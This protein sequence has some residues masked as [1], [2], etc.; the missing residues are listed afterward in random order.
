MLMFGVFSFDCGTANTFALLIVG[1]IVQGWSG[2]LMMALSQTLLVR[3]FPRSQ[4]GAAMAVWTIA[5]LLAPALG[6]IIGGWLCETF[7][8]PLI[9][10]INVPIAVICASLIW[11]RLKQFEEQTSRTPVD[12]VGF[13]LL[14]IFVGSLQ[15]VLDIGKDRDWFASL[16]VCVLSGVGAIGFVSFL[17]W[18]LT[19]EHPIVDLRVFRHRGFVTCVILQAMVFASAFSGIVLT[20]LWLQTYM[21]YSATQAGLTMAWNALLGFVIGPIAG[22]LMG[23]LDGRII[24]FSGLMLIV[25]A[26]WLRAHYTTD[27]S[28]FQ[29][30]LPI[31]I[32]GGGLPPTFI[33]LT[34]LALRSVNEDETASAAGLQ[35]FLRT[36]TSA[37]AVSIATVAWDYQSAQARTA[38][39]GLVDRGAYATTTMQAMGLKGDTAIHYLDRMVETQ[40]AMVGLNQVMMV[41]TAAFAVCACLV[42]FL[43]KSTRPINMTRMGH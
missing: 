16:E 13:I 34:A 2:G 17:I 39:S 15:I 32:M 33:P 41:I 36:A 11:R 14:V 21:G 23:R 30:V 27:M 7:S 20:P 9:F 38:M 12:I 43:P 24:S 29:I 8:W 1:R 4:V 3:V 5:S 28:Y 42:W 31:F 37:F 40:S 6:P 22:L 19:E 10:F 26:M 18:E 25:I 35:N